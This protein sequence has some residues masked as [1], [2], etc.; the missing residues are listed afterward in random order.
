MKK[1]GGFVFSDFSYL[2]IRLNKPLNQL[3]TI[4]KLPPHFPTSV[5]ILGGSFFAKKA[6]VNLA[7]ALAFLF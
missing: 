1:D 4:P 3:N 2:S 7:V 5:S 6:T